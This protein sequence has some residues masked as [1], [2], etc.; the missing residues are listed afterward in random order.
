MAETP[1]TKIVPALV[2][3]SEEK[4]IYGTLYPSVNENH[5]G[6]TPIMSTNLIIK[7]LSEEL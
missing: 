3:Y 4:E 7:C 1:F 5:G 2:S 6:L